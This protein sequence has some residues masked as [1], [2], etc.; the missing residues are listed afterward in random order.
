MGGVSRGIYCVWQQRRSRPAGPPGQT[1]MDKL[2][3][4]SKQTTSTEQGVPR[5]WTG[6]RQG[7]KGHGWQCLA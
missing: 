4:A 6:M 2:W 1:G 7:A 5:G 3:A